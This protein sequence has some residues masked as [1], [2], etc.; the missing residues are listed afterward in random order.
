MDRASFTSCG[1]RRDYFR[2]PPEFQTGRE[3]SYTSAADIYG[4]GLT[5]WYCLY[6]NLNARKIS[7]E[8]IPFTSQK[9]E[10]LISSK[11]L[12][13]ALTRIQRKDPRSKNLLVIWNLYPSKNNKKCFFFFFSVYDKNENTLK[14]ICAIILCLCANPKKEL[15]FNNVKKKNSIQKK[16]ITSSQTSPLY[17]DFRDHLF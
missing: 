17:F 5:M 14:N 12:K 13:I 10:S 9:N 16:H 15:A 8:E 11:W 7:F 4:F 1:T 6:G 3:A 2:M